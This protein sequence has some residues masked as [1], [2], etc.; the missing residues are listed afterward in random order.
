MD[1]VEYTTSYPLDGIR[2]ATTGP[3]VALLERAVEVLRADE[4]ILAAWLH[5]SFAVGRGDP[6]SD[7]DVHCCVDD[8]VAAELAGD[9]WKKMLARITPI[10]MS[11]SFPPPSVGGYSLTPEWLHLDLAF[12]ARS[13]LDVSALSGYRRLFDRTGELLR[14]EVRPA[15]V[16]GEPF[17]PAD[18]VDWFFYM[19]G[20]LVVVVG[21]NEPVLGVLGAMTIRETCAIPLFYAERG[22]RRSGGA[23]RLRPF[24][25][26]EQHALLE[27]LPPL[28]A[29]LDS[30]IE[31]ELA[32]ARIFVPRGRALAAATGGTWPDALERATIRHVESSIGCSVL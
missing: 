25:S 27:S 18:T 3:Q 17:Y 30:V 31:C 4:R 23:K 12:H 11:V 6:F 14:G 24:L 9:G 13:A 8:D 21:R 20:N 2:S 26:E 5:G 22:I 1:G 28:A 7:V 19:L 15:D 16:E 29:T 10:V 32:L